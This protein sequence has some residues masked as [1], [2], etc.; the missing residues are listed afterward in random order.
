MIFP[1]KKRINTELCIDRTAALY[2]MDGCI[3][4]ENRRVFNHGYWLIRISCILCPNSVKR[5]G[6]NKPG[7][8]LIRNEFS[9]N[10][11]ENCTLLLKY[12]KGK[13]KK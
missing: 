11:K 3:K 1:I 5:C 4:C 10:I 6:N 8:S 2:I 12:R 7:C 9:G 13:G